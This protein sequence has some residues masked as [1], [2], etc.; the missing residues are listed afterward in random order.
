MQCVEC[1][2]DAEEVHCDKCCN[3][4]NVEAQNGL[5]RIRDVLHELGYAVD[6]D[7]EVVQTTVD[8]LKASGEVDEDGERMEASPIED[9]EDGPPSGEGHGPIQIIPEGNSLWKRLF[10]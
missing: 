9:A 3:P 4:Y 8:L 7:D 2:V 6:E 10:R 1:L 5:E